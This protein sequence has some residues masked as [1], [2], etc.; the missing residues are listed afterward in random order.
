M[1]LM[2]E[3]EEGFIISEW[4]TLNWFEEEMGEKKKAE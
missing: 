3:Q 2:L 4:K 1:A